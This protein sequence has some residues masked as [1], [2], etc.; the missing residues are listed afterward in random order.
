MS[1]TASN[2]EPPAAL[3]PKAIKV[4]AAARDWKEAVEQAGNLL[5]DAGLVK[6]SYVGAMIS[7]M[8]SSGPYF[9]IAPGLAVPHA[10]PEDGAISAGLGVLVL[11]QPVC[12]GSTINDPVDILIPLASGSSDRHIEILASL[13]GF[14]SRPGILEKMRLA[15]DP[16]AVGELFTSCQCNNG[17][18]SR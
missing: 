6:P 8:E 17:S 3:I 9:V 11:S 12:F 10:R 2:R 1:T 5:V 14:L 13:A 7:V 15:K 16:S 4:G 18:N